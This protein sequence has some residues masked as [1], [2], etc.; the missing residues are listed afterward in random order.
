MC[1]FL[2]LYLWYKYGGKLLVVFQPFPHVIVCSKSGI[3]HGTNRSGKWQIE[4]MSSESFRK[5]IIYEKEN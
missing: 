3:W 2:G 4:K 5:W 1:L